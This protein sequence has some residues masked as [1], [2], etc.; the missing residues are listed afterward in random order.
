[1]SILIFICISGGY[2]VFKDKH[3]YQFLKAVD[4][5]GIVEILINAFLSETRSK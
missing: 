5:Y 2:H 3:S 1:M 4:I